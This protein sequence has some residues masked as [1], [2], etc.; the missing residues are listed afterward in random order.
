MPA[1]LT[2]SGALTFDSTVPSVFQPDDFSCAV[3]TTT[4]CLNS[5][6]IDI[7]HAE[8]LGIMVPGLVTVELGLLDGSG[9]TIAAL[10]RDQFN[11]QADNNPDISFDDVLARAGNQPMGIG[12]K[13]WSSGI[14]HWVGVRGV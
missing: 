5:I 7:T 6:G 14:G 4:W 1:T 12:G 2:R 3:A 9:G 10:L 11:L 13:N 8:M